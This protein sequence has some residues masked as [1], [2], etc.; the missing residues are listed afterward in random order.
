MISIIPAGPTQR[1]NNPD[2]RKR[3]ILHEKRTGNTSLTAVLAHFPTLEHT[4]TDGR[5]CHS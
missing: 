1:A 4:L 2:P 5:P 3:A